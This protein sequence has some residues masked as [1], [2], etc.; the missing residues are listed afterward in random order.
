M[1]DHGT[2][3]GGARRDF[4]PTTANFQAQLRD[5]ATLAR[6]AVMET[7]ATRY[8]K[9]VYHFLRLTYS[10]SNEDAKD[11]TQAFFVWLLERDLLLRFDP[12]RST[13]RTF[14]KGVLRNFAGN[15]HQALQRLKRGGGAAHVSIDLASAALERGDVETDPETM[16]DRLWMKE[17]LHR[18]L[19]RVRAKYQA[20]QRIVPFLVF[21]QYDLDL[22]DSPP[23]YPEVAKRLGIKESD[24][25]NHLHEVRERVREEVRAEISAAEGETGDLSPELS[26]LFR[27]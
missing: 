11:L 10:K 1:S 8:W 23:S 4:P 2:E 22:S 17:V 9:P 12:A 3:L 5:P 20:Q 18:A 26:K 15:E 7:L 13:F 16:F 6:M 24:V 27:S 14:L 25:R 19:E 21:Q